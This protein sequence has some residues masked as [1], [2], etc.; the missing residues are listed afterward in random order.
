MNP[1]D[2]FRIP[3]EVVRSNPRAKVRVRWIPTRSHHS[4]THFTRTICKDPNHCRKPGRTKI[5]SVPTLPAWQPTRSPCPNPIHS[6]WEMM[7]IADVF[8]IFP[9]SVWA[10]GS[11]NSGGL[12]NIFTSSLHI[13]SSS[14]LLIFTSSHLRI[15]TSSHLHSFSS[16]HL[17][18]LTS[19]HLHILTSSHLLIITSS[20]LHVFTPSHPHIFTSSHLHIFT[21]SHLHIFTSSHLLIFTASHLH[22]F[23]SSHP[24]IFTS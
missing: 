12:S 11:S 16:S 24:H 5:D 13:F 7:N 8:P 2:R 10:H 6:V 21:S 1:M 20:H 4:F 18:I 19:S 23:T 14:H 9:E 22:I 3:V 15:F 17:Y